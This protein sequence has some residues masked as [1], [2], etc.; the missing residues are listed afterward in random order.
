LLE[1]GLQEIQARVEVI[2]TELTT[3]TGMVKLFPAVF[4]SFLLPE[5]NPVIQVAQTTLKRVLGRDDGVEVWRFATDGGHL[6]AAG[7]P[8]IG[9]G[10]G[11][12]RLAHTNQERLNLTEMG[13]AAVAYAEL[14]P[15]LAEAT[16]N[17]EA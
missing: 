4:P 9:F 15:A 1:E 13:E 14:I 3:Y 12:E 10:P 7:I 6:M 16:L 5:N 11:D 17:R 2:T 8:T